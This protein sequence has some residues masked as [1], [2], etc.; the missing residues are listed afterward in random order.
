MSRSNNEPNPSRRIAMTTSAASQQ[1]PHRRR[2]G[3]TP[4]LE[5]IVQ[6]APDATVVVDNRGRIRLVNHQTEQ[7]FGYT[8]EELLGQYVEL[9][10]PERLR[11]VHQRHRAAYAYAPRVRSMGDSLLLV[12]RKQDGSEFPIEAS[13]GLLDAGGEALVIVSIRDASRLQQTYASRTAAEDATQDLRALQA[14]TDTALSHLSL[15]DLVPALLERLADVL[16]VDN[17]A[18]FPL[19]AAGQTLTVQGVRRFDLPESTELQA[20]VGQGFVGRIAATREPLVVDDIATFPTALSQF[21]GRFHS[22]AGV[23]LQVGDQLLGVIVVATALPRHFT[24]RDV[25]LTQQVADRI[26]LAIDR[27]RLYRQ[28]QASEHRYQ[29]LVEANI[30]GIVVGDTEQVLEANDAFL[31]LVG[32]T[33]E[34]LEAGRLRCDTL[35]TPD[36]HR[37]SRRAIEEALARAVSTP[38]EREFVRKDGS[39][40][41]AL[42][43]TALLQREPVRFVNFVLDLTER[44]RLE[45]D[46]EAALTEAE[47]QATQ[48]AAT[49]EAM[50][51]GVVVFG[52]EGQLVRENTAHRRLLGIDTAPPYWA[53]LRLPER[54]AHFVPRD[55]HGRPLSLDEG[56]LPRA[57]RGEV[58]GGA[59]TME[60]LSRTLDG[61]EVELSVSAAPLRD[62]EG[63]LTGAVGIFRDQTEQKRLERE[64]GEQAAELDHIFESIADGLVVYNREGQLVRLDAAAHQILGLDAAPLDYAQLPVGDRIS[65]Y[66][67]RDEDGHLLAFED[68]PLVSVLRGQVTG[69]ATRELRLRT[70]DGRD[71]QVIF[72]AAPVRDKEANLT[73]AVVVLHDLTE[74]KRLAEER[75]EAHAR[76]LAAEE[77][78]KQLDAFFATAAHDIRT[79]LTAVVGQ[80]QLAVRRAKQLAQD[81][82]ASSPV[83]TS[84]CE[85]PI[86]AAYVVER[87]ESAQ[88]GVGKLRRLV[89]YLFDVAQARAGT[90][91]LH[92]APCDLADLVRRNVAIQR[93]AV[94]GRRIIVEIPREEVVRV[95]ADADRLDQVISNYL[96]NALKYSP[97][98]QPVTVK[99]EIMENLAVV[100]VA[101]HGPGLPVGEQRRV[102]ELFHRVPGVEVQ[103][104]SSEVS[105]SLGLGLHICKQ[106]VEL[107]PGGRVGVESVLGEG[108]TFWFRLPRAS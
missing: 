75:E 48:L 15:D 69:V 20:A 21:R 91:T 39:R 23:P 28:A 5:A 14:L 11:A 54:L 19:D 87:L 97:A 40:V 90:L 53:G 95:E 55:V 32:Y 81:L 38:V 16:H 101:D 84:A 85:A 80:M 24:T 107:H 66:E 68:W 22:V 65:L 9:L 83:I 42:V 2:R 46:R 43:G 59:E 10:L 93:E 78:A 94:P 35:A 89:E 64:R 71:M 37:S 33:R 73:G 74:Y 18:V 12:G 60:M 41:W 108:S 105:G 70:L 103:P 79:P 63:C 29:R 36:T 88:S 7:L 50:A 8:A 26:A 13:L 34:D 30:I 86:Q 1:V 27:S 6:L 67:A 56:P 58:L 96:T 62:R 4:T 25:Q 77:L 104:G 92:F 17:A 31:R 44:K 49:F 102:W 45:R 100:S 47:Q 99:L 61:R 57:L 98:D 82:T 51:D 106:L 52:A 76:E 72:S 3:N